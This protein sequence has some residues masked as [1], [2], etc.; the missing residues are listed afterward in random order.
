MHP[1]LNI[2]I[3]AIRKGGNVLIQNYDIQ[4]TMTESYTNRYKFLNNIIQYSEKVISE[5]IYRYYPKHHIINKRLIKVI[6]KQKKNFWLINIIDGTLN[7]SKHLPHF[8]ISI[9]IYLKGLIEVSVIYDP[10][11]NELF[12]SVKGRGSRLNGYRIRCKNNDHPNDLIIATNFSTIKNNSSWFL[13]ENIL[14]K[15]LAEGC[16]V[17]CSGSKSLDLAYV[18]SGR[19]NCYLGFKD[20]IMIF[21]ISELQIRESGGLIVNLDDFF[22]YKEKNNLLLIG[23]PK[24][25]KYITSILGFN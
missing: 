24:S 25:I 22:K 11:K 16:Y 10:L 23:S 6:P 12:S 13:Y 2:A 19:I 1:I 20:D 14:K 9:A 4:R 7:Y 21:P 5:I 8:C 3:R 18:A 15:L 17:R